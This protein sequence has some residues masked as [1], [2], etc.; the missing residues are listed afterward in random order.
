MVALDML[1]R[2]EPPVERIIPESPAMARAI[3]Y[4]VEH[5]ADQPDLGDLAD[6][7]GMHPH[8]F[9]RLF[10]R[11]AGVSPKRFGQFLTVEHA[12]R[13]L[14]ES[15]SVLD[16]ALEVGLSGPSRLHDLF[17]A[18]EAMTPGE[19]KMRGR[20]LIIHYGVHDSP[21]GPALIAATD[22][23]ICWLSFLVTDDPLD[24]LNELVATWGEATLVRDDAAV[25]S[26]ARAAFDPGVSADGLRLVI[27]GTNF[28]VKVWRAL[29]AIPAGNV[30]SYRRIAEAVE[31]PLASRAVGQ[32]CGANNIA[33]LIPCHR[34]IRQ[35]G[36]ID[37]Y[38]WSST[39]KR[40]LVAWESGLTDP[41]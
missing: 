14:L 39:Q 13:L 28:Q 40:A 31:N 15:A 33:V 6:L 22:R 35:S 19:Y 29:L 25:A 16:T 11:W 27:K 1:D 12:K 41:E 7:A 36:I 30:A 23:G 26:L 2:L 5:Y 38:R 10:K 17:V 18:C 24:P 34:V 21:F 32:A 20:D 9:Q 37:G 8:H 4:L 3:R